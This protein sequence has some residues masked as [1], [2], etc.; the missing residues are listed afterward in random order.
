[1][2][3]FV[4]GVLFQYQRKWTSLQQFYLPV[5]FET[6]ALPYKAANEY[7]GVFLVKGQLERLAT[8]SDIELIGR[9]ADGTRLATIADADLASGWR[10][11]TLSPADTDKIKTGTQL[12]IF[13][14]Q[15]IYRVQSAWDLARYPSYCALLLGLLWLIIALPRDIRLYMEYKYGRRLKGTEIVSAHRYQKLMGCPDGLGLTNLHLSV[16]DRILFRRSSHAVHIP[17]IAEYRHLLL[18]GDSGTGKSSAIRQI[19]SQIRDRGESAVIYDP[20]REYIRHFFQP[21]DLALNPLDGRFPGWLP[22]DEIDHPAEADMLAEAIFPLPDETP[23]DK[24]FFTIA[25]RDVLVELLKRKPTPSQLYGWMRDEEEMIRLLRG[26]HV[27]SQVAEKSPGQRSGVFGTLTQSA[28]MF[29]FLPDDMGRP[30]WSARKWTE[31]RQ[32]WI[33]LTS[34]PMLRGRLN[35]LITLWLELLLLRVMNEEEPRRHTHFILDELASLPRI[36]QLVHAL[37][38]VRKAC[39]TIVVGLQGKAQQDV[40]YGPIA[41][42]MVSMAATKILM[43]TSE[44]DAAEWISRAIG[45]VEIERYRESRTEVRGSRTQNSSTFQCDLSSEPLVMDSEVMGLPPLHAYFRHGNLVVPIK[46]PFIPAQKTQPGFIRRAMP[47]QAAHVRSVARDGDSPT[48]PGK[49]VPEQ[50]ETQANGPEQTQD[51]F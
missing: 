39:A 13:L 6:W 25:A 22:S 31:Q 47:A 38:E 32:G 29:E 44:P 20:A 27:M 7:K 51:Y 24:R 2:V 10:Q 42:A 26:T 16:T 40:K 14:T 4:C 1:M 28:K 35:P 34:L 19:L 50:A 48:Q 33:F 46:M 23:A 5:Y 36:E 49:S 30:H 3:S 17:K 45:K 41:Q 15:R 18:L 8:D 11:W 21:G 37:F 12:H 9:Q 43:G